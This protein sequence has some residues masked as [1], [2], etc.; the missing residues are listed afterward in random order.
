M[1]FY[2]EQCCSESRNPSL[3]QMVRFLKNRFEDKTHHLVLIAKE[4]IPAAYD[5]STGTGSFKIDFLKANNY[6]GLTRCYIRAVDRKAPSGQGFNTPGINFGA[7]KLA[8]L[9]KPQMKDLWA[10]GLGRLGRRDDGS[11]YGKLKWEVGCG[12]WLYA[13]DS[14]QEKGILFLYPEALGFIAEPGLKGVREL[15]NDATH[16]PTA[17]QVK[18]H[19]ET[20]AV[21]AN[22]SAANWREMWTLP[23]D[24]NTKYENEGISVQKW[25]SFYFGSEGNGMEMLKKCFGEN[26]KGP[27]THAIFGIFFDNE[28]IPSDNW[29]KVTQAMLTVKNYVERPSGP[30]DNGGPVQIGWSSAVASAIRRH[31]LQPNTGSNPVQPEC[32]KKTIGNPKK[33]RCK[34]NYCL[35]Q[36][37]T[38]GEPYRYYPKDGACRFSD[39]F[40]KDVGDAFGCPN[41]DECRPVQNPPGIDVAGLYRGVPMLCGAGDCQEKVPFSSDGEFNDERRTNDQIFDL[42]NSRPD[43]F[44]WKNLAIWYGTF[45]TAGLP[46]P[47][48]GCCME[49]VCA[50]S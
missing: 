8:R 14:A 11:Y 9:T 23:K 35:G 28:D 38:E 12:I 46:T 47:D 32:T 17:D 50:S 34:W 10:D 22:T 48:R 18:G 25:A 19:F 45:P 20:V 15:N 16:L 39:D 24:L 21:I 3:S 41:L 29:Q 49:P 40:W 33:L 6:C 42:L 5:P 31:P 36:A 43:N 44:P 1:K 4:D 30:D 27:N 13:F 2:P 26:L 7:H 37:Y